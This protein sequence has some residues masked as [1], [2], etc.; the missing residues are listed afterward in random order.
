MF[1]LIVVRH[2]ESIAN[3]EGIYQGQKYDTDLS[4]LGK[5]QARVLALK[6]RELGIKK[7]ITSPL[8]RTYQTALEVSKETGLSIEINNLILETGHGDWEG[9]SKNWIE[10][11][12]KD[13][14]KLWL[15]SPSKVFFPGGET[16]LQT[17]GRVQKFIADI[18]SDEVVLVVTH[19]NIV[20]ILITM[21]NGWTLDEIWRH[22]IETASL[23]FFEINSM[24][25]KNHLKILK[26]NDNKHLEGIRADVGKHAL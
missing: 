11:N 7:I 14:Y 22:D 10:N 23:N 21:A 9:K 8:K 20:R 25:G 17:Y 26:L 13:L 5:K 24:D 4:E 12:Y 16:F 19:D 18:N 6:V 2:G 3:T 1:K 15:T